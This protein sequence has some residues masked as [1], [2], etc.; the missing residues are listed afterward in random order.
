MARGYRFDPKWVCPM[1]IYAWGIQ[2]VCSRNKA[3][4]FFLSRTLEYLSHNFP[5]NRLILHQT[6]DQW[7]SYSLDLN[8]PDYFLRGWVPERQ[9]LWK[10][11]TDNRGHHQKRN[12]QSGFHQK[13]SINFQ[14]LWRKNLEGFLIF[15]KVIAK[16]KLGHFCASH[17]FFAVIPFSKLPLFSAKPRTFLPIKRMTAL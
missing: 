15:A 7:P 11:P 13:N 10:Q 16:E 1:G 17:W 12:H 2:V 5:W 8:P 3:P 4:S 9:S 6:N 14:Y